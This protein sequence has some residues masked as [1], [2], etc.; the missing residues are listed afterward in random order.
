MKWTI[1]IFMLLVAGSVHAGQVTLTGGTTRVE[2]AS[3]DTVTISGTSVSYT[4]SVMELSSDTGIFIDG[5]GDTIIWNTE[6]SSGTDKESNAFWLMKSRWSRDIVCSAVVFIDNGGGSYNWM[7]WGHDTRWIHFIDCKFLVKGRN[8]GIITWPSLTNNNCWGWRFE[9]CEFESEVDSFTSRCANDASIG[10]LRCE[11]DCPDSSVLEGYYTIWYDSCTVTKWPHSAISLIGRSLVD[12]CNVWG[13]AHNDEYTSPSGNMCYS[14]DNAYLIGGAALLPGTRIVG[15]SLR[16]YSADPQEGAQGIILEGPQGSA[17]DRIVVKGNY[18]DVSQ[19]PSDYEGGAA[20]W[21]FRIRHNSTTDQPPRYVDVCSNYVK[22]TVD[23]LSSTAHI[24]EQGAALYF[25]DGAN[26]YAADSTGDSCRFYNNTFV[27]IAD[28]ASDNSGGEMDANAIRLEMRPAS[29]GN[30]WYDNRIV[31][32][33]V[34]VQ[35]GGTNGRATGFHSERDTFELLTHQY[36]TNGVPDTAV[37]LYLGVGTSTWEWLDNTVIDPY[38]IGGDEDVAV[39]AWE[40]NNTPAEVFFD[41][42]AVITVQDSNGSVVENAS[43]FMVDAY[44]DTTTG[45]SNASGLCSL[46]VSY[47][48]KDW[49]SGG[50][51]STYNNYSIKAAYD[52]DTAT[53]TQTVDWAAKSWTLTLADTDIGASE[54]AATTRKISGA[55][56]TGGTVR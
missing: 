6:D 43:V 25:T 13:Q 41:V 46:L 47:D 20:G 34:G 1:L 53:T 17:T 22:I 15:C 24:G 54:P 9:R 40:D 33:G 23:T 51:D 52:G 31:S 21:G 42:H 16:V 3:Y 12:T 28:S 30:R 37:S 38:W 10:A 39:T 35:L 2:L 45:T 56:I 32:N 29:Q 44:S 49:S 18:I 50:S 8:S 26:D 36:V 14:A 4:G 11:Y 55:T 27:C 5:Q 7:F 19:G 48:Y